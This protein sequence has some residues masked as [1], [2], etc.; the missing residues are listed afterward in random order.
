M[1]AEFRPDDDDIPWSRVPEK[2]IT[3]EDIK[4][5]LSH[6][7]QGTPYDPYGKHG[8]D[9]ERGKFRPIGIN[10]NN[11]LGLVQIRPYMPES[12]KAIQWMA[13]GSTVFNAIVPFY[14]NI[15][16]SLIHI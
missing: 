16:L 11:V 12:I 8:D 4:Y 5:A 7:F 1:D 2:K 6:H 3:V 13:L 14:P 9:K 10:R 15:D